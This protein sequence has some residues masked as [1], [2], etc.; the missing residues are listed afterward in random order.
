MEGARA[1]GGGRG[2][3]VAKRAGVL[4]LVLGNLGSHHTD[5]GVEVFRGFSLADDLVPF[6][7][8]N[9][10]DSA[11]ARC[12]TLLHEL[13]HLWVGEPGISGGD[14]W[15]PW[16][17]TSAGWIVAESASSGSMCNRPT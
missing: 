9:P 15:I 10:K 17:L 12:F 2:G 3:R 6:V 8:V 11:A 4:V 13:A 7:V 16:K 1:A 5:L 14:P